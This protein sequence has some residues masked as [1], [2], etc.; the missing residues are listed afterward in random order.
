MIFQNVS[1]D[2][3]YRSV[4]TRLNDVNLATT[5]RGKQLVPHPF[6]HITA[7]RGILTI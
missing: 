6:V 2:V 3:I 7:V 5:L 4:D 1:V